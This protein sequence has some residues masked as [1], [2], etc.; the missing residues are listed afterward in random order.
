MVLDLCSISFYAICNMAMFWKTPF[1]YATWP[2]FEKVEYWHLTKPP[3]PEWGWGC[4]RA[5]YLLPCC[6]SRDSLKFDMQ[7]GH[8]LKK[9]NFDLLIPYP[10]FVE[11][12]CVCVGGGG[13][14]RQNICDH[15]AAFVIPFNLI[16]NMN[17]FCK[18]WILTSDPPLGSEVERE[19]LQANYLRPC[20][21]ICDPL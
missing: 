19:G 21:C 20:F 18:S 9:L 3:G 7:H 8:V 13:V 16:C 1:W 12:V 6:C 5:K 17:V 4:L 2:C 10:R 11:G 15:V 14:C